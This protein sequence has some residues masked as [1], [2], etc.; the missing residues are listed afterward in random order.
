MGHY[1]RPLTPAS[2]AHSSVSSYSAFDRTP[3]Q[4][5]PPVHLST[6]GRGELL[7]WI[8]TE[9]DLHLKDLS[10][11]NN[12]AVACQMCDRLNP[13]NPD[14][15]NMR[16]VDFNA[17]NSYYMQRNW[18]LLQQA[19]EMLELDYNIDVEKCQQGHQVP[20]LMVFRFFKQRHDQWA[21][22]LAATGQRI[23]PYDAIKRRASSKTGDIRDP[24][25][26]MPSARSLTASRPRSQERRTDSDSAR[27]Y[28]LNGGK[29]NTT[30]DG[31]TSMGAS[32]K[33]GQSKPGLWK[34]LKSL[35]K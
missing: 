26:P 11:C 1:S 7:Q 33:K 22:E 18:R 32:F 34:K 35:V 6:I 29:G 27:E 5:L 19:F 23:P 12:G 10:E 31:S 24:S 3:S 4:K 9:L 30:Q 2:P 25:A 17:N 13:Y 28:S 14:V 21:A 20:L 8:N 16:R 15:I